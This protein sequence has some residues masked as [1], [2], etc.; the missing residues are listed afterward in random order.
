MIDFDL[1][2]PKNDGIELHVSMRAVT[3]KEVKHLHK[4]VLPQNPPIAKSSA[5]ER[6]ERSRLKCSRDQFD[7]ANGYAYFA[8]TDGERRL[9]EKE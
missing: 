5:T 4:D 3:V 1:K 6:P 9:G 8:I 2:V 7:P